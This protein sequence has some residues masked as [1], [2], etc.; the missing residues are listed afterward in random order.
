MKK[1]SQL[2]IIC[3]LSY[4]P[5]TKCMEI[6]PRLEDRRTSSQEARQKAEFQK[7]EAA[8]E[9]ELQKQELHDRIEK[10]ENATK[11]YNEAQRN[12]YTDDD[13]DD[14][15]PT[16]RMKRKD[17]EINAHARAIAEIHN[18]VVLDPN[19]HIRATKDGTFIKKGSKKEI[20]HDE[21]KEN[22]AKASDAIKASDTLSNE[23]MSQF[24]D[25]ETTSTSTDDAKINNLK[26]QEKVTLEKLPSVEKSAFEKLFDSFLDFFNSGDIARAK[27]NLK[28]AKTIEQ[29]KEALKR[30][31]TDQ[32]VDVINH[33]FENAPK[34]QESMDAFVKTINDIL[35]SKEQIKLVDN[36]IVK[37]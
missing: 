3:A 12:T 1:K 26:E 32:R 2:L 36:K 22:V 9:L 20:S 30:L 35:P 33:I 13:P 14:F 18:T 34:N 8:K 28:N 21:I 24:E 11:E 6:E 4:N 25:E 23:F 27:E 29:T 19:E 37:A 5:V 7:Q 15:N 17:K 10:K 31:S 16:G